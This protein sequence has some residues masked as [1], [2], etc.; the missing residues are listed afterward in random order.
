MNLYLNKL[1]K[2]ITTEN[3][4]LITTYS[5]DKNQ[6]LYV[7]M[8]KDVKYKKGYK[9]FYSASEQGLLTQLKQQL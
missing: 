7:C 5:Y 1:F 9:K 4:E 6:K 8:I 3:D 2:Q